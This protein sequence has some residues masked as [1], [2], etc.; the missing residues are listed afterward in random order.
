MA[1]SLYLDEDSIRHSVARALR[2]RG[3][4]VL[5]VRDAGMIQR[6]DEEHLV[7]AA[8]ERRVVCT[9]NV[10]DFYRLHTEYLRS[11][12]THAGIILVHQQRYA[13]GELIRRLANVAA[14]L[15]PEDIAS[16]V[17]FLSDWEPR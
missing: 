5:T 17:E 12:K 4:D 14:I 10:G 8:T 11:G 9:F 3:V 16:S 2:A 7:F 6:S 1:L 13:L 15:S